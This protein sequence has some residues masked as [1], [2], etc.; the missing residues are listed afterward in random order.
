[1]MLRGGGVTAEGGRA[2]INLKGRLGP[3][4]SDAT[5]TLRRPPGPALDPTRRFALCVSTGEYDDPRL[6]RFVGPAP[7]LTRLLRALRDRGL[8]SFT[9]GPPLRNRPAATVRTKVAEFFA[10]RRADDVLLLYLA[11]V[12]VTDDVGGLCWA[13]K[14]TALKSAVAASLEA[15]FL[16][17]HIRQCR[18]R[19]ILVILDC[20]YTSTVPGRR[21]RVEIAEHLSGYGRAV[22]TASPELTRAGRRPAASSC[23]LTDELI[24]ALRSKKT[25]ANGDGNVTADELFDAVRDAV[26]LRTPGHGPEMIDG[27]VGRRLVIVRRRM[28]ATPTGRAGAETPAEPA[29]ADVNTPPSVPP[30]APPLPPPPPPPPLPPPPPATPPP[31]PSSAPAGAAAGAATAGATGGGMSSAL[32]VIVASFSAVFVVLGAVVALLVLRDDGEPSGSDGSAVEVDLSPYVLRTPPPGFER[33]DDVRGDECLNHE[34]V[35]GL[36]PA[37][38]ACRAIQHRAGTDDDFTELGSLAMLFTDRDQAAQGVGVMSSR[39]R[40]SAYCRHN[41][42][43]LPVRLENFTPELGEDASGLRSICEIPGRTGTTML[44][45]WRIGNVVQVIGAGTPQH[46]SEAEVAALAQKLEASGVRANQ[47]G[48]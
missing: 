3:L 43:S 35:I 42:E 10:G 46:I 27:G 24:A 6:Q 11:G 18:S 39:F 19:R 13:V 12:A 8:A 1:M 29:P 30:Q 23:V 32:V 16:A 34:E 22:I 25:D 38:Q 14:D 41:G 40:E 28:Q 5:L 20:R 21:G 17:E 15:S 7:D 31:G 26:E 37:P 47:T 44:Y 9:A 48:Q 2:A 33:V 45:V 36:S 4:Q